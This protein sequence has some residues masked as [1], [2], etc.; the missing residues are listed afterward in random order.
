MAKAKKVVEPAKHRVVTSKVIASGL[1][2]AGADGVVAGGGFIDQ[3]KVL[4]ARTGAVRATYG[5][6]ARVVC[7]Y[8]ESSHAGAIAAGFGDRTV[9]IWEPG[10]KEER[11]LGPLDGIVASLAWSGDGAYLFTGN[12]GDNTVRLWDVARGAV[13]AQGKTKTSATWFVAMTGDAKRA[14]SGGGGKSIHL[15]APMEGR[16][17]ATLTGHTGKI[18]GLAFFPDGKRVISASQDKSARIWDLDA[19]KELLVLGGHTKEVKGVAVAPD[20]TQVASCST[21]GTLRLWDAETGASIAVL[22]AGAGHAESIVYSADGTELFAGC[23]D[24]VVRAF[25][26]PRQAK[27]TRESLAE[28]LELVWADPA[29]DAPRAVVADLLIAEGDPRGEFITLQLDRARGTTSVARRKRE[30]ELLALH[31]RE[32]IGPIAPLVES[33]HVTF[34][35]G[36]ISGCML[37]AAKEKGT[38]KRHPAWSTIK[39]FIEQDGCP[40]SLVAHLLALGA[41]SERAGA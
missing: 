2:R 10:A 12:C 29:D 21:D 7:W 25:A 41:K 28:L 5:S 22:S 40:P 20:G 27:A 36:F 19:Q 6:P 38:P 23:V 11:V 31:Q 33:T 4:D 39:T 14:V 17:I 15:W 26:V 18:Q 13:V 3:V 16:E 35:R 9:R 1:S 32:W 34:E 37:K 8:A 24:A 30:R